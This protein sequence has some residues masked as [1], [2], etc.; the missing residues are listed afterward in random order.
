M[1]PKLA[2]FDCIN[3]LRTAIF[4]A[5]LFAVATA[6][7]IL[8][9]DLMPVVD[10]AKIDEIN[11]MQVLLVSLPH[12]HM[13]VAHRSPLFPRLAVLLDRRR[14]RALRWHDP[15]RRQAPARCQA[16]R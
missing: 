2:E 7:P 1:V 15:P 4:V 5:A 8:D 14:Q 13:R 11:S 3:M 10:R 16:L 12:F 6:V 9:R